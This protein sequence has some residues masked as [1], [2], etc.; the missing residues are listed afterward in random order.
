MSV[1]VR[2]SEKGVVDKVI[3]IEIG[4]GM[5][6]VKV[7]VRDFCIFELGDKFVLRYG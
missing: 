2:L 5:K 6:L 1:I 3:V 4:D 7:I